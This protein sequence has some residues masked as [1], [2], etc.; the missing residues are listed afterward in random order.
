MPDILHTVP[1]C[2]LDLLCG[3]VAI[4]LPVRPEEDPFVFSRQS[5]PEPSPSLRS[6]HLVLRK[7]I[8]ESD[9]CYRS[10]TVH[11]FAN[12]STLRH[13]AILTLAVLFHPTPGEVHILL[14]HPES[15]IKHF[16]IRFDHRSEEQPHGYWATPTALEYWV[17]SPFP[18][19]NMLDRRQRPGLRLTCKKG[20]R[21]DIDEAWRLRDTVVGFG[22]Q[23]ATVAMATLLLDAAVFP[24]P[25]GEYKLE[26]LAGNDVLEPLSADVRI[27]LPGSELWDL[28]GVQD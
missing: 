24:F 2:D 8:R 14:T 21:G 22:G 26:G 23:E 17:N 9:D 16:R 5:L 12:S 27:I 25:R 1:A 20:Y 3:E 4:R 7:G 15:Q 10:D 19:L 6:N 11:V 28:V 18:L 13:L